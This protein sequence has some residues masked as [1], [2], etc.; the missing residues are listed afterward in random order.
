MFASASA[1]A[2][3]LPAAFPKRLAFAVAVT[4][5]T[6]AAVAVRVV[7][8]AGVLSSATFRLAVPSCQVTRVAFRL[9]QSTPVFR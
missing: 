7:N 5:V 3:A 2:A 4:V 6:V 9:G 8:V 1:G